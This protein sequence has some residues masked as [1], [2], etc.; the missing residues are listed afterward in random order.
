MPRDRQAYRAQL[1]ERQSGICALCK[2]PMTMESMTVDHK[3]ALSKGG[4]NTVANTQGVHKLCNEVKA[5]GDFD[6]V[7]LYRAQRVVS[8]K[9]SR[10]KP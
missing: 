5:D 3:I 6:K 4:R 10:A 7:K 1:F 2:E 8:K 9:A